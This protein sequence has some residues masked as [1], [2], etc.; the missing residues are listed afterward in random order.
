MIA[1]EQF[2]IDTKIGNRSRMP[3]HPTVF[4]TMI[5]VLEPDSFLKCPECLSDVPGDENKGAY[6]PENDYKCPQC[7]GH[8]KFVVFSY[9]ETTDGGQYY[10][11][12]LTRKN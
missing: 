9:N 1:Q 10:N 3:S 4:R 11:A 5:T 12:Q 8:F 7:S 2:L 6:T